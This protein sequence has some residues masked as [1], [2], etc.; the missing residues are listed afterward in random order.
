MKKK[1]TALI[2]VIPIIFMFTVFSAGQAAAISVPVSVSS[3][4]I[5]NKPENDTLYADISTYDKEGGQEAYV[6]RVT[7]N[8]VAA[9]NK[10]YKFV[11]SDPNVATVDNNNKL[12]LH[13]VGKTDI[14]VRSENGG[15]SDK[16]SVVVTS[17]VVLRYSVQLKDSDNNE[18]SLSLVAGNNDYQ[19]VAQV[20]AGTYKFNE[21]DVH[22]ATIENYGAV[23]A[24]SNTNVAT[25]SP[26]GEVVVRASGNT[27]LSCEIQGIKKGVLLQASSPVF[28][29]NSGIAI[30]GKD[31]ATFELSKTETNFTALVE[32]ATAQQ[33]TVA[34]KSPLVANVSFDPVVGTYSRSTSTLWKMTVVLFPGVK[35][36]NDVVTILLDGGKS[37]KYQLT[38]IFADSV[39]SV[40]SQDSKQLAGGEERTKVEML[41]LGEE[42]IF[43][44]QILPASQDA[45]YDYQWVS[46]KAGVVITKQENGFA[47]ISA[48][49]VVANARITLTV[50]DGETV[51]GEPYSFIVTFINFYSLINIED[52]GRGIENVLAVGEKQYN[53]NGQ[54][55]GYQHEFKT[56]VDAQNVSLSE[57][58]FAVTSSANI[59][60]EL[61][62]GKLVL[63]EILSDEIS[64]WVKIEW[65][66]NYLK[67]TNV[68]YTFSFNAINEGVH[69]ST[70]AQL[71]KATM[72]ENAGKGLPV[73]LAGNIML[74]ANLEV[75]NI[76]TTADWT[77]YDKTGEGQPF[78]KYL[79]EFKNSVYGNGYFIS[80]HNVTTKEI[81]YGEETVRI[82]NGPLNFVSLQMGSTTMASVKAQDNICFL[83]C[84]DDVIIDNIELRGCEDSYLEKEVNGVKEYQINE[85]NNIGTVLELMADAKVLN[86]R[87]RNGRTCIRAF[88]RKLADGVNPVLERFDELSRSQVAQERIQPVISNCIVQQAREFLLKVGANRAL[89][90]DNNVIS[91]QLGSYT[92]PGAN[93]SNIND[94]TFYDKYVITDITVKDT[95]FETSGLF[96]IGVET[97]FSGVFLDNAVSPD[98]PLWKINPF[99]TTFNYNTITS[100]LGNSKWDDLAATSYASKVTLEGNVEFLDWKVKENIDSSTLIE[101]GMDVSFLKLRVNKMVEYAAINNPSLNVLFDSYKKD[102]SKEELTQ[103][104]HGGI[105]FYGGGKNYSE[106]VGANSDLISFNVN[107]SSLAPANNPTGEGLSG[108][109]LDAFRQ[110]MFLPYAAGTD[111]FRFMMYTNNGGH[112]YSK[113]QE[114]IQNEVVNN[115]VYLVPANPA[116]YI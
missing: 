58:E 16:I 105:C 113:V 55:T 87:I 43:Y 92:L 106:V 35:D 68:A 114:M 67:N 45:D 26:I 17:A 49:S 109:D 83:V 13:D 32:T 65:K 91:P 82:F 57:D 47:K 70:S 89:K 78:V 29:N 27:V 54:L 23:Y 30:E 101:L 39:L 1:I 52:S 74:D 5:D 4:S 102:P 9:A 77:H 95:V 53:N 7:V 40:F 107:L 42:Y 24:S 22:P 80:A 19:Y 103:V 88:G 50:K 98:A 3:I 20:S 96:S 71:A 63:T 62:N 69:V 6:F 28:A 25:I 111:D 11:S 64:A 104:L 36:D 10:N 37:E 76:K 84:N 93:N 86:S 60:A 73:V 14:E 59:K 97:H 12:C 15:F 18:V 110:G 115:I 108:D 2:L 75:Q 46:D 21:K 66:Y 51:I 44:S 38:F 48:T 56:K 72:Q 99:N 90:C 61:V 31:N 41:K 112:S 34:E 100:I 81:K 85:L 79:I 33:P 8:P 116:D 94:K